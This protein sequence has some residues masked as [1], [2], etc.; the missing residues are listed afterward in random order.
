MPEDFF[1]D[2]DVFYNNRNIS[3]HDWESTLAIQHKSVEAFHFVESVMYELFVFVDQF[4]MFIPLNEIV[5]HER[6]D[7]KSRQAMDSTR[8]TKFSELLSRFKTDRL[9][10]RS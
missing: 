5:P 6:L 9:G 7:E 10:L 4:L 8:D 2:L 1:D 3:K